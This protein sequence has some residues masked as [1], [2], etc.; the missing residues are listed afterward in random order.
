M[1]VPD[2]EL[3]CARYLVS[4][5]SDKQNWQIVERIVKQ[6]VKQ[7]VPRNCQIFFQQTTRIKR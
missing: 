7:I 6:T 4:Q 2:S 3:I 5:E 1:Q